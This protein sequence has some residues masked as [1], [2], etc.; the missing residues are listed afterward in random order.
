MPFFSLVVTR[1]REPSKVVSNAMIPT[2][3]STAA[4]ITSTTVMPRASRRSRSTTEVPHEEAVVEHDAVAVALRALALRG[5]LDVHRAVGGVTRAVRAVCEDRRPAG[6]GL[7]DEPVDDRGDGA[8]AA[9]GGLVA[10][11]LPERRSRRRSAGAVVRHV[12]VG[13]S[14]QHVDLDRERR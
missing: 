5:H 11:A 14:P 2:T 4:T 8:L 3:I 6:A 13:A 7:V 12:A 1:S 10:H 9:T